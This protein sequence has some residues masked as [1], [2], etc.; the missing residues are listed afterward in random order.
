MPVQNTFTKDKFLFYKKKK[1]NW[2]E[3]EYIMKN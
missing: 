3:D 1:E 2:I